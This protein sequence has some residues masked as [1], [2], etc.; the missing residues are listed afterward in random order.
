MGRVGLGVKMVGWRSLGRSRGHMEVAVE[1]A[2][3]S[4]ASPSPPALR[5]RGAVGAL[6]AVRQLKEHVHVGPV[7]VDIM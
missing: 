3:A 5:F 6:V 2:V 1:V 4:G 7:V